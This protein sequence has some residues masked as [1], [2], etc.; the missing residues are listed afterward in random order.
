VACGVALALGDPIGPAEE[1]EATI[2]EFCAYSRRQDWAV[3]WYQATAATRLLFRR[4]GLHDYKIGEEAVVDLGTF[5]QQGK[6]GERVRHAVSRARRGGVTVRIW[7]GEAIPDA[8]FAGM[9]RVSAAW[10]G[11]HGAS[12]QMGFS[13]GRFP[14]EWSPDLL[15]AVALDAEGE[16]QAFT[17]WTPLYAGNGWALDAMRRL[18][19]AIPGAMELLIAECFAWA[20]ERGCARA[21]LGLVPLAGLCEDTTCD[22][23]DAVAPSLVERGAAYLQRRK[24]L[25]GNY[26]ALARFKG[27][28]QPAW[29]PRYLV[30]ADRA[31]LP[32][33]LRALAYVHSYTSLSILKEAALALRPRKRLHALG[34]PPERTELA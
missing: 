18:P 4:A 3:A 32:S 31:A 9:K 16:V 29:E 12:S 34:T 26:A 24:L 1:S 7:Q 17:T 19:D 8:I 11:G 28:F 33:V 6:I 5:T 14:A 13:M 10:M 25:L 20:R 15:T 22:G 2:R 21:S 23:E 27:Q 30:V